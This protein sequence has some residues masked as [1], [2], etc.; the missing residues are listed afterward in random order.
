META[1]EWKRWVPTDYVPTGEYRRL[2]AYRLRMDGKTFKEVGE[3]LGVS[4]ER[5]RQLVT[6]AIRECSPGFRYRHKNPVLDTYEIQAL[7]P[8]IDF[9]REIADGTTDTN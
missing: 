9:L 4:R 7:L 8:L 6:R 3:V 5:A 2:L 1:K